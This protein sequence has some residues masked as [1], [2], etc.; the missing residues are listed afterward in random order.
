MR[1]AVKAAEALSVARAAGIR[2]SID[3]GDLVLEASAPP[4][5]S[6]IEQLRA[7]KADLLAALSAPGAIIEL[8]AGISREW[9]VGVTRLSTMVCPAT[10]RPDRWQRTVVDAGCFLDRW[11]AEAGALGW[12]TLNL[13]GAH[14]THPIERLDCAGLV[15]LLHGDELVALTADAGRMRTRSGALLTY[16]RRRLLTTVPLWELAVE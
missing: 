6:V 5:P 1:A 13:F 9:T 3:G 14:P 7:S 8:G 15:L 16:Y 4:P 2:V 11:G 12:T 10:V